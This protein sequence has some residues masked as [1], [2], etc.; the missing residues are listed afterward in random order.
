MTKDQ[1]AILALTGQLA[2]SQKR[3]AGL[4]KD[5]ADWKQMYEEQTQAYTYLRDTAGKLQAEKEALRIE[6][7]QIQG[8]LTL[9]DEVK[10]IQC[11]M[12]GK[13]TQENDRLRAALVRSRKWAMVDADR[14]TE[15]DIDRYNEDAEFIKQ[16]LAGTTEVK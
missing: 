15:E 5:V 6:R 3:E 14:M 12:I 7:D 8:Y 11:K 2:A 1:E 13:L 9:A 16:A 10:D 4:T